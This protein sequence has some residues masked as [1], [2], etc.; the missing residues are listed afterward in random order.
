MNQIMP[1]MFQKTSV[2]CALERT[3]YHNVVRYE[4]DVVVRYEFDV[5]VLCIVVRSRAHPTIFYI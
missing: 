5:V 3:V 1:T 4:F 2:G